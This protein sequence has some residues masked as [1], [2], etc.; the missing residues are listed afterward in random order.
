M[1]W[2]GSEWWWRWQ[3]CKPIN[4][5]GWFSCKSSSFFSW[6]LSYSNAQIT[7]GINKPGIFTTD[8]VKQ[9]NCSIYDNKLNIFNLTDSTVQLSQFSQLPCNSVS[10][11]PLHTSYANSVILS[12][13]LTPSVFQFVSTDLTL[14]KKKHLQNKYV[15]FFLVNWYSVKS[16]VKDVPCLKPPLSPFFYNG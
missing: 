2:K 5:L 1:N 6:F 16:H 11:A 3:G 14:H 10:I 8:N 9:S 4:Y 7:C 13:V 15:N 12:K